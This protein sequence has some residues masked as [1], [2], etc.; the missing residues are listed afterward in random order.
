MCDDVSMK[1]VLIGG[2][3]LAAA[4]ALIAQ[5][6]GSSQSDA[7]KNDTAKN[8]TAKNDSKDGLIIKPAR[9]IEFTTDE[10]TWMNIDASKDGKSLLV[11]IL[12]DLYTIPVEGGDAK[13]LTTGMAWDYQAQYSPDGKQIAFVR[14]ERTRSKLYVKDLESG[15]ERKI[16]DALDQDVQE[17]W[18]VTGVYPNMAWLPD[19]SGLVFW[20]KGK[21]RRV[22][23]DGTVTVWAV[24]STISAN[25]DQGAD[26]NLLVS[27]TDVLSNT[28]PAVGAKQQFSIIKAAAAGE[29]ELFGR[30]HADHHVVCQ[31]GA[32]GQH[33]A[34]RVEN[35]REPGAD[36]PGIAADGV[37]EDKVVGADVEGAARREEQDRAGGK[38]GL[39]EAAVELQGAS[40]EDEVA[41]GAHQATPRRRDHLERQDPG[42]LR[43][44]RRQVHAERSPDRPAGRRH[45]DH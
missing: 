7:S 36:F 20:A 35:H 40:A 29:L 9:T 17:T 12:G 41:G 45:D 2:A 22:N 1:S 4:F 42:L 15:A 14:R 5:D 31:R 3:V 39:R 44:E 26:P 23:A 21:I 19:N 30:T 25:G 6:N 38:V 33:L 16:Y 18:A 27:I 43:H 11:D 32:F 34:E 13:P 10:A 24:T 28:D 8:E 37:G